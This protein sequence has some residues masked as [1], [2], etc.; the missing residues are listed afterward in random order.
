[1]GLA[2]FRCKNL[3]L[4]VIVGPSFYGCTRPDPLL[5]EAEKFAEAVAKED[6][7]YLAS[8]VRG[9]ELA[10]MGL[11]SDSFAKLLQQELFLDWSAQGKP[12]VEIY[13]RGTGRATIVSAMRNDRSQQYDKRYTLAITDDGIFWTDSMPGLV[14]FVAT[15]KAAKNGTWPAGLGKLEAVRAFASEIGPEWERNYGIKGC[16]FGSE[17]GMITWAEMEKKYAARI[18]QASGVSE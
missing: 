11:T 6:A 18:A 16:N 10:A 4:A 15:S 9:E 8:R 13:E 1:M 17:V 12:V 14:T 5:V 7:A 2:S 3:I